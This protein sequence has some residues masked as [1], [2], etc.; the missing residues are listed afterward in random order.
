[1]RAERL[2]YDTL[3][4]WD[5]LY[6]IV[7]SSRRPDLRGLADARGLGP[8]DRAD[9]DRA[10]GRGEHVPQ[11]G[12]RPR[13]WRRP[14]TTSATAGRSSASAR[15]GSRRSTR[16]S[17]SSSATGPPERLRWLGRGA[18]DHA[19]HAR[20]RAGRRRRART[21]RRRTSATIRR[22]SRRSCRCCIG[23]GGEQVTLKLVARYADMNNVG[24]G[25][26]ERPAQGG[27]PAP[28]LRGRRARPGRDRADDGHRDGLHPRR[29]GP[30]RSGVPRRIFARERRRP[31]RG[32]TSRSG[33]P[34]T[35]PRRS[36]RSSSSATATSSSGFPAPYDE[37][38]MTRLATE[39][40]P[41]LE[42]S[43]S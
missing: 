26:R 19:R 23:G 21:T 33:R 28:P 1:M 8:G 37:E 24:G 27:D 9:P 10:D 35:W 18:A 29:T 6:P 39:V 20:R 22:R 34:R 17:G 32:P 13:R 31:S 36:R 15:R 42:R 12:A 30:R 2:G 38:S 43:L 11:P 5:H 3:W 40:R 7:G 4:T 16:P 14:S 41:L 25:D